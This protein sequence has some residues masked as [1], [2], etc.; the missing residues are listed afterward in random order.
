MVECQNNMLL[1]MVVK[2]AEFFLVMYLDIHGQT[3]KICP[4]EAALAMDFL[5]FYLII[6]A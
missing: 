2:A 6:I 1:S 4:L 3:A 5:A